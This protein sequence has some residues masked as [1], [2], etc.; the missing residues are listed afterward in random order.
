MIPLVLF[1]ESRPCPIAEKTQS[2]ALED[3]LLLPFWVLLFLELKVDL[4]DIR[5]IWVTRAG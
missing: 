3:R 2:Y 1:Y 4:S 5:D